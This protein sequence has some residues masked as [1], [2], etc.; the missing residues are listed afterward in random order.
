MYL[1]FEEFDKE[2]DIRLDDQ[3]YAY[4][5]VDTSNPIQVR[6]T[7]TLKEFKLND[8]SYSYNGR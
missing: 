5:G 2:N 3:S 8:D 4:V 1:V 6:I 7:S